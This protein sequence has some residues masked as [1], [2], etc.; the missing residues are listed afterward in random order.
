MKWIFGLATQTNK[1]QAGK[2]AVSVKTV[3]E[4]NSKLIVSPRA[5]LTTIGGCPNIT[6]W[7]SSFII[8]FHYF[9]R[10]KFEYDNYRF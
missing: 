1:K 9:Y 2:A 3:A 6:S 4:S 10:V 8:Y 5:K 7:K